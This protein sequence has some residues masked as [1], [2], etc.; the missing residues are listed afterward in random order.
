[1]GP[2]EKFIGLVL[3]LP[4][5]LASIVAIALGASRWVDPE[6]RQE[7][8]KIS[9]KEHFD[10]VR[11]AGWRIAIS[12]TFAILVAVMS[13]LTST[14][15]RSGLALLADPTQTDSSPTVAP[16]PTP[17]SV[18]RVDLHTATPVPSDTPTPTPTLTHISTWTP[19][20]TPTFRPTLEST[21]PPLPT[22]GNCPQEGLDI[23]SQ[24]SGQHLM[25]S[26]ASDISILGSISG[27][28]YHWYE[29]QYVVAA[30]NTPAP[31]NPNI[32]DG[33]TIPFVGRKP[34]CESQAY[35]YAH[36]QD[37]AV[38]SF[39]RPTLL[40]FMSKSNQ[41]LATWKSGDLPCPTT[42]TKVVTL[43]IKAGRDAF[44]PP[45]HEEVARCFVRFYVDP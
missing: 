39:D 23:T 6:K 28:Q 14:S 15:S 26:V 42:E 22:F 30:A 12:V 21:A 44:G 35:W 45:V 20:W 43:W 9:L 8:R 4:A 38:T 37:C 36:P 19:T 16:Q 29:V 32:D 10:I 27:Q 33:N 1:M 7:T 11:L 40:P 3:L 2:L 25:C 17:T 31:D 24:R 18:Y 34:N 41:Y 13:W 5:L